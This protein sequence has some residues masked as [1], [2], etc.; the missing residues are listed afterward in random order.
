MIS[1]FFIIGD[2][3]LSV[4]SGTFSFESPVINGVI[5][6]ICAIDD[7]KTPIDGENKLG[8]NPPT[9]SKQS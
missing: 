4:A 6:M 5:G 8:E 7:D 9:G 3:I 2:K 1:Y